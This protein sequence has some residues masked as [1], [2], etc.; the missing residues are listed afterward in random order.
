MEYKLGS[1]RVVSASILITLLS[2]ST[3]LEGARTKES[4]GLDQWVAQYVKKDEKLLCK[5][6]EHGEYFFVAQIGDRMKVGSRVDVT[7]APTDTMPKTLI[8]SWRFQNEQGDYL[9]TNVPPTT[10]R[11]EYVRSD[12][13]TYAENIQYQNVYLLGSQKMHVAVDVKKCPT[14]DCERQQ[15]KNKG[16]KEYSIKLCKVPLGK[17]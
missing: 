5:R 6:V 16:E 15:T 13:M 1:V 7:R 3:T 14:A 4:N 11:Q 12:D 8:V 17:Q 9:V 10:V 2:T